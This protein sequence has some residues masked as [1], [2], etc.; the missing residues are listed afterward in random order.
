LCRSILYIHIILHGKSY[1]CIP[2]WA[3]S[4]KKH[5]PLHVATISH[6]FDVV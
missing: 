1:S 4:L 3:I 5:R 2:F 6:P